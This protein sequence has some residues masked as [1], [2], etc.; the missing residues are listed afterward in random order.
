MFKHN[1]DTL[2]TLSHNN[3][4]Y[5]LIQLLLSDVLLPIKEPL[6]QEEP[7]KSIAHDLPPISY[8]LVPTQLYAETQFL[9]GVFHTTSICGCLNHLI[10]EDL[11]QVKVLY[12]F[13][14]LGGVQKFL[15]EG[16]EVGGGGRIFLTLL[17][18]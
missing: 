14:V 15:V 3:S 16:W 8:V 5:I 9:N 10:H 13:N 2:T 1:S 6:G 7:Q 11:H 17:G 12:F 4:F 18:M